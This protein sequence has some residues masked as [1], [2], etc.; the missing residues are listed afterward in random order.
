MSEPVDSAIE[1]VGA[2]ARWSSQGSIRTHGTLWYGMMCRSFVLFERMLRTSL[3]QFVA[4]EPN[5]EANAIKRL[6]FGECF[7]EVRRVV[8]QIEQRIAL[9]IPGQYVSPILPNSDQRIWKEAIRRRNKLVHKGP[10]FFDSVDH[11]AGRFWREY[12]IEET[13]ESQA[14]RA[15][16]IGRH[17]AGSQLVLVAIHL[18]GTPIKDA[19]KMLEAA[20]DVGRDDERNWAGDIIAINDFHERLS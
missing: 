19:I 5:L 13:L 18:S 14:C 9:R 17:L 4:A 16:E 8:P 20:Q 11:N 1:L 7:A 3:Q 2:I 15:W 10:G 12:R 6:T